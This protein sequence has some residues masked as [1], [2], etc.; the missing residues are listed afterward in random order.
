MQ[1]DKKRKKGTNAKEDRDRGG[2]EGGKERGKGK[3]D[4]VWARV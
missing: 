3:E 1:K 2:E 4:R